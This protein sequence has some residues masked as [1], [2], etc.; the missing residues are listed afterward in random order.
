MRRYIIR[1]L[2]QAIPTFLGITILSYALMTASGNPVRTLSFRPGRTPDDM[3]R[4]AARLGVNDPWPVQYVRWLLGDDWMRRDTDG[5][6]IADTAI[7]IELD[8]DGDGEPD[9]PGTRRGVLRGDFGN[10]F[11]AGRPVMDILT[12]RFPATLELSIAGIT[13][14]ALIGIA[15]GI[16]AAVTRGGMFD[17]VSRVIAVAF[18]AIPS[19]WLSIMLLLIFSV[20]LNIFPIGD[21]CGFTLEPSCPPIYQRLEYMVLPVFVFATGFIA[22]YSR[23]MRA[24]ML[25]ILNKDYILT[26]R[27]KGLTNRSIWFRHGARNAMI[28]IATFLGPAITSLLAGAVIIERIFN[29]PGVGSTALNA[30]LQRD[31]PVVMA[32]TIYAGL[33]TIIGYLI[34]DMLYAAIDPRIRFE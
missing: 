3:E 14:G 7:I 26:A 13:L 20:Q 17:N 25:D 18:D 33:A 24:S 22:A 27:A 2:I 16:I 1:R 6:G 10:S 4:L 28:P 21:R 11:V 34:S 30:A 32:T 8:A 29:Y 31:F 5:D 23:I 15:I 9:P 12:E 19:F